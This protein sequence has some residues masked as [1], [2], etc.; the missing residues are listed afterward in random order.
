MDLVD[1]TVSVH[2]S[3]AVLSG[4]R[5]IVGPP[6]SAAGARTVPIPAVLVDYCVLPSRPPPHRELSSVEEWCLRAMDFSLDGEPPQH[7]LVTAPDHHLGHVEG[8]S[9]GQANPRGDHASGVE[10]SRPT[11]LVR[12]SGA[13]SRHSCPVRRQY[14]PRGDWIAWTAKRPAAGH[15]RGRRASAARSPWP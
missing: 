10:T 14:E 7:Q 15:R 2:R 1:G 4:G 12:A 3:I 8:T 13:A 11:R 9:R 6:K 5:L